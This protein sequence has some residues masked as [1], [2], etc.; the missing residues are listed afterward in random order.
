MA[1][2]YCRLDDCKFCKHSKE[3]M[4][5]QTLW[6]GK[7]KE[8]TMHKKELCN[9]K[10]FLP[11]KDLIECSRCNKELEPEVV[12]GRRIYMCSECNLYYTAEWRNKEEGRVEIR[13]L[14]PTAGEEEVELDFDGYYN[15]LSVKRTAEG[16]YFVVLESYDE[17]E[18]KKITRKLYEE[19]IR[20]LRR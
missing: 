2:K 5:G 14:T 3:I 18:E 4:L 8:Y 9:G 7:I 19:M 10:F 17:V 6:C 16:E 11:P 15:R 20:E 13:P 12:K 1:N